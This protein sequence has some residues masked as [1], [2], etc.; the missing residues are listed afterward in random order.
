LAH[1][2]R[3][4]EDGDREA[5]RWVDIEAEN[6]RVAWRWA[7]AHDETNALTKSTPTVLHYCDHRSRHE[8]GLSLLRETVESQ[9]A[10]AD[11]RLGALLLSAAAHL[12]YRLDRYTD[13]EATA[14]HALAVARTS[15]DHDAKLQSLKV[16]GS[17]CLRLGRLADAKRY[18]KQALDEAPA[19]VDPHNAAA[20]LAHTAPGENMMGC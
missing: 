8:V 16:L 4:V 20:M 17:C 3:A 9:A 19:K 13:A 7:A 12:E 10:R 6:C 5:L 2:R 11:P 1:L 15:G 14:T 18:F